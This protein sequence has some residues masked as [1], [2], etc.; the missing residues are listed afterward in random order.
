M[1]KRFVGLRLVLAGSFVLFT[2]FPSNAATLT[3]GKGHQFQY[4]TI[5]QAVDAADNG[6]TIVVNKGTYQGAVINKTLTIVGT[7]NKANQKKT[8]IMPPRNSDRFSTGFLFEGT[9]S[10]NDPNVLEGS[11]TVI[12]NFNFKRVAFPVYSVGADN[13]T[14]EGNNMVNPIQGITNWN[15]S[16]WVITKN[17]ITSQRPVLLNDGATAMGGAGI[18]VGSGPGSLDT[19]AVEREATE[20][21]IKL[22]TVKGKVAAVWKATNTY[23]MPAIALV[24]NSTLPV[25]V[26]NNVVDNNT[27]NI[28]IKRF[29]QVAPAVLRGHGVMLNEIGQINGSIQ[30]NSISGN[31]IYTGHLLADGRLTSRDAIPAEDALA[32]KPLMALENTYGLGGLFNKTDLGLE[33]LPP[34]FEADFDC[35]LF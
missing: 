16:G 8:T 24:D 28:E 31:L 3:V 11:N 33:L 1:R 19:P 21:I 34:S 23:A 5:Q 6:D 25:S 2:A 12:K 18:V 7:L 14:V 13:I 10:I 32:E 4:S 27:I 17:T 35:S 15:G 22:N 26:H 30:Q 29:S 20:N 9:P